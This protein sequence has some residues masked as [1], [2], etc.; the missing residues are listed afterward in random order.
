MSFLVVT[1]MWWLF[2]HRIDRFWV[3]ALPL[4]ALVAG[5]G[6]T[7]SSAALWRRVLWSVLILGSLANLALIASPLPG[8]N[9]Y[10]VRLEQLRDDPRLA[11]VPVAHRYLNAN[12][13]AGRRALLVGD[14]AVFDLRVS[15]LYNTCFDTCIF[16]ELLRGYDPADRAARLAER[17][18]SHIY[19][20]WAEIRRY[21]QPGNYGF[22]DY[23]TPEFVH[24]ELEI[25]QKLLRR[26]QV[27]DL[28]PE[29]GELFEVL[30]GAD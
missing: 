10:F 11:T 28:D 30:I 17:R 9:R 26:I 19:V 1:A 7:W 16:E 18:V 25:R 22:T 24:D 23:V 15:V 4:L 14:A 12:L 20:N 29:E 27:P 6:A 21:R 3:P 13:P 2:T 8:D 5:I